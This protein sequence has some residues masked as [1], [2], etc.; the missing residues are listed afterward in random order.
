MAKRFKH[1]YLELT[2]ICDRHC[3]FCPEVK[4]EKMFMPF[5]DAQN[6]LVQ[7][8]EFAEAVYFHIQG[9][10]L[11]HPDFEKITAFAANLGLMLKLT[12][13]ASHLAEHA[14]YLLAG[15]FYQIN[16]SLQSLN[17]VS[18][19]ERMRVWNNIADF[20][21]NAL[22]KCPDMYIN[23][24]WWQNAPPDIDFFAH[25]FSVPAPKWHPV[26]GRHNIRI[27]GRLY[28]AFDRE[29]V[30][31]S[32]SAERTD[33]IFGSCKGLIDHC[34]ILCDGRVV[35]CCLDCEG[36]L[37]LGNLHKN[38]LNDILNSPQARAIEQGFRQN[39]RIHRICRNCNFAGRF[40]MK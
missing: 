21:E 4:R 15:N 28:A 38:T 16:F 13:N 35:P 36:E 5:E 1:I 24:R 33:G 20:T 12:T 39:R 40:D 6:F 3:S 31:P 8:A 2:D 19:S 11:L 23:F 18:E 14:Q 29:F 7:S 27:N 37:T 25:R 34:G 9:E 22:E 32:D 10:P 17:E 30:W 26:N